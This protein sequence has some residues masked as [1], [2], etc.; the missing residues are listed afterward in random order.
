M[1][2]SEPSLAGDSSAQV[3]LLGPGDGWE[4]TTASSRWERDTG[5]TVTPATARIDPMSVI[6]PPTPF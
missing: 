1:L 5:L 6:D 2:V 4:I 3:A